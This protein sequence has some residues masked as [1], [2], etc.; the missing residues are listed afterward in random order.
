MAI[1]IDA[2]GNTVEYKIGDEPEIKSIET[3]NNPSSK[4]RGKPKQFDYERKTIGASVN[5]DWVSKL[6]E[7][8]K[9]PTAAINALVEEYLRTKGKI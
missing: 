9:S 3:T 5:A 2:N 7:D 4:R 8:F 1:M 6:L